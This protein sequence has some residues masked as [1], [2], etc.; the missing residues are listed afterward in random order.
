VVEAILA[1]EELAA[2]DEAKQVEGVAAADGAGLLELGGDGLGS[3][4]GGDVYVGGG[5]VG[6]VWG[7]ADG[8]VDEV[9]GDGGGDQ[10]DEEEGG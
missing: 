4:A 3:S 1:G 10:D 7:W 2:F 9:G 8:S 6:G 5:F